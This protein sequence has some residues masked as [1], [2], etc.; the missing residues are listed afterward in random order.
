MNGSVD[1]LAPRRDLLL[2]FRQQL[3]DEI[4]KRGDER[5]ERDV[6]LQEIELAGD[7]VAALPRDRLVDF[8]HERRLADTG[9]AHDRDRLDSAAR[10]ALEAREQSARLAA[11][12]VQLL[13]GIEAVDDVGAAEGEALDGPARIESGE[14]TA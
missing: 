11:A 7:E 1:R 13:R 5:A 4:L 6:L 9:L 2:A 12:S 10:H 14:A 3:L 8:L